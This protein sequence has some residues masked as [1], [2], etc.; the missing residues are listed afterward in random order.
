MTPQLRRVSNLSDDIGQTLHLHTERSVCIDYLASASYSNDK[1]KKCIWPPPPGATE[2]IAHA[3]GVKGVGLDGTRLSKFR[4][5]S[6]AVRYRGEGDVM[7]AVKG[8]LRLVVEKWLGPTVT[9]PARIV[10]VGRMSSGRQRYVCVE[11]SEQPGVLAIYFFLHDDG[12]WCVF[13]PAAK[14]PT[15][16]FS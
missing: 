12:R 16:S 15:M 3:R 14:H 9:K 5:T 1:G 10:R 2:V 4:E 7:E 11:S 6:L 8:S 13:P